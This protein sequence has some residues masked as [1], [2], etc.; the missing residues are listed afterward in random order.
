MI[1]AKISDQHFC[2]PMETQHWSYEKISS[3][4]RINTLTKSVCLKIATKGQNILP[5]ILLILGTRH[6]EKICRK[7]VKELA[8]KS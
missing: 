6:C 7:G 3:L 4:F 1:L 5:L 8:A 2:W